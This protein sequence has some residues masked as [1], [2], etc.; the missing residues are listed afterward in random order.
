MKRSA[1]DKFASATP[2]GDLTD[3]RALWE[4][5]PDIFAALN[6]QFGPFDVDLC[7]DAKRT[8]CPTWLGPESPWAADARCAIWPE[9]GRNGF[10]NPPYGRFVQRMLTM[11]QVAAEDGFS[12]THL[13]PFRRQTMI[14]AFEN[15]AS[16][17]LFCDRRLVFWENGRPRFSLDPKT[18]VEKKRPDT[19]MFDSLIIRY[20]PGRHLSPYVGVW[21]VPAH[22]HDPK[23]GE[24]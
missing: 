2:Q 10:N 8:L 9:F 1:R 13:L 12:S 14:Q 4:T 17:V 23:K 21:K 7:A 20:V 5:D 11:A 16:A 15:G 6:V 22:G 18:G 19:A 3:P 24:F